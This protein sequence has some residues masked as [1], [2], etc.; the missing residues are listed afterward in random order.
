MTTE[1]PTKP[2]EAAKRYSE[3]H[4]SDVLLCSGPM[5]YGLVERAHDVLKNQENDQVLLVLTTAGGDA[6]VA[7]RVARHLQRRYKRVHVF[8]SGWCKSAGTLLAVC[9]HELTVGDRGELGPVDVQTSRPDDLWESTSG[10]TETEA[11]ATL[12]QI[13]WNL[14][15]K[16]ITETKGL[17]AS[18]ITFKTAA[19][20]AG[21]LVSGVLAPIF[22][23]IDP[24]KLGENSR[25]LRIALEYAERLNNHSKNI[26]SHE[27][28]ERL[29]SGYPDHA[30]VIDRKEAEEL[31]RRVQAPSE[32]LSELESTLG[33][34]ALYPDDDNPLFDFLAPT[35]EVEDET[36]EV[37]DTAEDSKRS[38]PQAGSVP[39]AAATPSPKKRR[40]RAAAATAPLQQS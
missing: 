14:F 13:S 22:A 4:N 16:L 39:D 27:H 2:A 34:F 37:D 1:P 5:S 29:I 15:S 35:T 40:R 17:P 30:F 23:Q 38:S 31:F 36:E 19:D 21:P 25:A 28:I 8:V 12:E 33:R 7:Y 6:H 9:G 3:A 26:R 10:L 20:A 18:Q 32:E 11:L 24:L